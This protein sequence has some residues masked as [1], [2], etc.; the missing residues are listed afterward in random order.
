MSDQALEKIRRAQQGDTSALSSLLREHYTFL[1]KYL[2]KVTM[3]PLLAEDLVQDTMVR[4][5]EK[6]NTYNGSS[7]FSSWLITIATRIFIDRKRRWK[8]EAEWKKREQQA[9]G[10]RSIR[11]RFE[12]RG[13]EWSEVLDSISKLPSAQRVA[14]L[15]KHYYG[16]SYEEIGVIMQIPSGTAKSRVSLGLNQLRKELNEDGEG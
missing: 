5:M 7:S 3:D 15:L 16:Y 10:T 13:E 8:R 6:I 11:W 12:S 9:Q 2:L 4:C 14:V 1:F